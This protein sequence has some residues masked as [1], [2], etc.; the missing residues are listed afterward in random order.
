[1]GGDNIRCSC[2]HGSCYATHPLD[3]HTW[4]MLRNTQGG[5]VITSIALAHM[6]DV[7]QHMGWAVISSV[8]AHMAD[9]T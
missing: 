3:L 1:M 9:A 7:M 5:G 4:L 8:A 6:A 2:T